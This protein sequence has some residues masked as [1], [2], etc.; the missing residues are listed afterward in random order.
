[1]DDLIGKKLKA[2][3]PMTPTE[4]RRE[5]WWGLANGR[6]VPTVFEFEDGTLLYASKDPEGNA[7]GAMFAVHRGNQV[8]VTAS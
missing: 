2:I 8:L 1:M 4:M 3:R 5:G 6:R 7:P